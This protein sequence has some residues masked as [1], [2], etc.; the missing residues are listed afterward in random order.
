MLDMSLL[1]YVGMLRFVEPWR[2]VRQRGARTVSSW[3]VR[4]T[5]TQSAKQAAVILIV[6]NCDFGLLLYGAAQSGYGS[7]GKLLCLQFPHS[8]P[9]TPQCQR[10]FM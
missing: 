1:V 8:V 7:N 2:A 9:H 4:K 10:H 6:C 3:N 5:C